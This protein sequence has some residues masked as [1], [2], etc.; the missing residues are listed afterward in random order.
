MK[1]TVTKTGKEAFT[2]RGKVRNPF[3][4]LSDELRWL[5]IDEGGNAVFNGE[6]LEELIS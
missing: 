2:S 5:Y 6:M 1:T 3:I 4:K